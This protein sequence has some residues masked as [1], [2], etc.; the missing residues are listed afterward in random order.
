MRHLKFI[1]C[2]ECGRS[3]MPSKL[4]E[5]EWKALRLEYIANRIPD[6]NG[7]QG[8]Q[9]CVFCSGVSRDVISLVEEGRQGDELSFAIQ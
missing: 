5:G 2:Q 7:E 9:L 3:L 4:D 1:L 8:R 6:E